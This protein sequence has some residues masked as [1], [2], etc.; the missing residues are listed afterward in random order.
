MSNIDSFISTRDRYTKAPARRALTE[1]LDMSQDFAA[2]ID[3]KGA[4]EAPRHVV[5]ERLVSLGSRIVRHSE[6]EIR[7]RTLHITIGRAMTIPTREG[8]AWS[9]SEA[10]KYAEAYAIHLGA[11]V[12]PDEPDEQSED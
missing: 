2:L 10:G 7:G 6:R 8:A 11:P 5:I 4:T 9:M 12:E 3:M 1:R